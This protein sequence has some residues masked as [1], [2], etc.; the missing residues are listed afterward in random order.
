M[1]DWLEVHRGSAPL[2]VSIP[3]TGTTIPA[4]IEACLGSTW[5]GRRDADWWVQELYKD[6]ADAGA[7]TVRTDVA[8]T[9]IDVNRDPTGQS[10]YP[11]QATT[12]LCPLTTFDGEPLYRP[13]TEPDEAEILRRRRNYFEPYHAV[14]ATELARLRAQH[15]HVVLYDAHSIRSRIAHLF[16]GELPNFNIGSNDGASCD[17][18]LTSAVERA[19]AVAP[20]TRITNGRFR[21]GWITRHYGRPSRGVH[22]IQMELAMRSYLDEP[23]G[24]LGPENWPPRYDVSRAAAVRRVLAHVLRACLEF[25]RDLNRRQQT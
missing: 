17:P 14:L 18:A 4:G 25:A 20:F 11:G 13:D 8:R 6:A 9:V 3:H 24:A 1:T 12:A 23:G 2:I 16:E 15:P 21:G 22:A 7:T 5:L 10:L 19:C